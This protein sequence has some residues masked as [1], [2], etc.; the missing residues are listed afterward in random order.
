VVK[1]K[2]GLN[3]ST[4]TFKLEVFT[5]EI[6]IST[7]YGSQLMNI[8]PP[9]FV[10]ELEALNVNVSNAMAYKLPL[11]MDPDGDSYTVRVDLRSAFLFASYD[12]AS[13]TLKL[14]PK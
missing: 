12:P 11:I 5:G 6:I 1:L 13:L 2:D 14:A 8:G 9:A 3:T 4:Y 10:K 7:T